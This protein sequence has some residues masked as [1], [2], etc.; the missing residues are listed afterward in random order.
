[1]ADHQFIEEVADNAKNDTIRTRFKAAK[2]WI[3]NRKCQLTL[4]TLIIIVFVI[5]LQVNAQQQAKLHAKINQLSKNQSNLRSDLQAK[6]STKIGHLKEAHENETKINSK[7]IV[8]LEGKDNYLM[9]KTAFHSKAASAQ[10]CREL[11]E[12]GFTKDGYYLVDPDGRYTGQPSFEVFCQFCRFCMKHHAYTKV[13]PKTRTFEISSQLSEDFFT[14][15]VYDGNVKQIEGLIEHSGSCWQQI[16]FGCLV[17]PLHFEGINHGFWKDRSGTERYFYDGMDYNGRKCQCSNTNGQCQSNKNA[18]CNCDVRPKFHSEDKGTIRAEWILPITAFGYKFHG[19]SLNTFNAQNG[20][21]TVTI[22]DLVCKDEFDLEFKGSL[23]SLGSNF[24]LEKTILRSWGPEFKVEFKLKLLK[25]YPEDCDNCIEKC[26]DFIK[27]VSIKW[28]PHQIYTQVTYCEK[29]QNVTF[30]QMTQ[31]GLKSKTFKVEEIDK[32]VQ[33][34]AGS[35]WASVPKKKSYYCN[36]FEDGQRFYSNDWPDHWGAENK[37]SSEQTEIHIAT[38]D[39][40]YAEISD[41]V[42]KEEKPQVETYY[43]YY[44]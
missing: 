14:E 34:K 22:G 26:S 19:H 30:H 35:D 24:Q 33:F 4:V 38:F 25:S 43:R 1:M 23:K 7:K 13:I 27:I 41:L 37:V 15:I 6:L 8:D 5:I 40:E 36:T 11:Y 44:Q 12:H 10:S 42:I 21:A 39:S 9:E 20:S 32:M 31:D 29:G 16:K 3:W 18:L 2:T 17:M 28:K